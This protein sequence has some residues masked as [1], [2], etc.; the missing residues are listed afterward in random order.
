MYFFTY[1]GVKSATDLRQ[2]S[3]EASVTCFF[4]SSANFVRLNGHYLIGTYVWKS[5]R[6]V[7]ASPSYFSSSGFLGNIY[8]SSGTTAKPKTVVTRKD[9]AP[10]TGI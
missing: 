4:C 1:P 3:R 7:F 2:Y 9:D 6:L 8:T 10:V 5:S